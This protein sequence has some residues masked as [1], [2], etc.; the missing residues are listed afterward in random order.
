MLQIE[1]YAEFICIV[2]VEKKDSFPDLGSLPEM[3][4]CCGTDHPPVSQS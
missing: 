4:P 2:I 1:G 3:A